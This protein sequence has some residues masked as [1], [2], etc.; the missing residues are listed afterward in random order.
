MGHMTPRGL[1]VTAA[2][3]CTAIT[4]VT[5]QPCATA[6]QDQA[7]QTP[8]LALLFGGATR[9]PSDAAMHRQF[10]ERFHSAVGLGRARMVSPSLRVHDDMVLTLAVPEDEGS[11][12]ATLRYRLERLELVGIARHPTPVAFVVD[13]HTDRSRVERTR[14]LSGFE[15]RALASM[16][17]A[18]DVV[19]ETTSTGRNV[20]GAIRATAECTSCHATSN[21]GDILGAF[22]YGLA[23]V[24]PAR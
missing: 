9:W 17:S 8:S 7:D 10:V 19:A 15:R 21:A 18:N 2:L 5:I 11:P 23:R 22:S 6:Q 16:S 14:P 24:D 20:L 1:R 12:A 4:V 13:S 3:F